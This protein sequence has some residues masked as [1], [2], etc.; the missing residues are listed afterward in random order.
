MSGRQW[1]KR[2][3]IK[4]SAERKQRRDLK[5]AGGVFGQRA[6]ASG[7]SLVVTS[8]P[9]CKSTTTEVWALATG[10]LGCG[11]C[12]SEKD[13]IWLAFAQQVEDRRMHVVNPSEPVSAAS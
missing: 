3:R 9:S 2:Q 7:Q 4:R 1:K 13:V 10:S 6:L 12:V 11:R 8:C 5:E